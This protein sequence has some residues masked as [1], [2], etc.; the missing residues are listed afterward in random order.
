MNFKI[1]CSVFAIA[2][3]FTGCAKKPT[4]F[5][6][7]GWTEKPT[8]LSVVFTTPLVENRDD[9]KDDLAEYANNFSSWFKAELEKDLSQVTRQSVP[10]VVHEASDGEL[11]V[12]MDS[13][14]STK[15]NM[16]KPVSMEGN[17]YYLVFS[18]VGFSRREEVYENMAYSDHVA[19]N[20]Y[21][22]GVNPGTNSMAMGGSTMVDMGLWINADYAIYNARTGSRVAFGHWGLK[23]KFAYAMTRGDWEKCVLGLVKKTLAR[24]PILKK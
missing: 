21:G 8:S 12:E 6:D 19:A 18:N 23:S 13:I 9:L 1:I 2:I 7:P 20:G 4:F 16:K 15:F 24:T 22:A 5:V 3:A 11:V 14:Q 10:F 17:G